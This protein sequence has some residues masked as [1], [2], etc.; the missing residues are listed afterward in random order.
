MV[1]RSDYILVT[2]DLDLDLRPGDVFSNI[3]CF[4]IGKGIWL[5]WVMLPTIDGWVCTALVH[6]VWFAACTDEIIS[7]TLGQC[8]CQTYWYKLRGLCVYLYTR[9]ARACILASIVN[10][11]LLL[12][13]LLELKINSVNDEC[14]ATNSCSVAAISWI[15][16]TEEWN[17][18]LALVIQIQ[19]M[20][21]CVSVSLAGC[22]YVG[23]VCDSQWCLYTFVVLLYAVMW[24]CVLCL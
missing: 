1:H 5:N 14:S 4:G 23:H 12:L 7:K 3:W 21:D 22:G 16:T 8:Q 2:F 17:L 20:L 10:Y 19:Y 15:C 9:C 18:A 11:L 24:T 6:T 13:S